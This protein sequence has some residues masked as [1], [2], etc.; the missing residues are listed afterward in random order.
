MAG[1]LVTGSFTNQ[2][3]ILNDYLFCVFMLDSFL[4]HNLW[5]IIYIQVCCTWFEQIF[6][7]FWT[8][9]RVCCLIL[10]LYGLALSK[11]VSGF[12]IYLILLYS[13]WR[14]ITSFD[15]VLHTKIKTLKFY[16]LFSAEIQEQFNYFFQSHHT[17]LQIVQGNRNNHFHNV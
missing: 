4:F 2:F 16:S 13:S 9:F 6:A 7:L 8:K 17:L 3:S 12:V 15:K 1:A 14:N 11:L 10:Y 5:M